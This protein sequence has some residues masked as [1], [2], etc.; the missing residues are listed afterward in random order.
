MPEHYTKSTVEA[1]VWCAKC[2]AFTMHQV[3]SGR[4]GPCQVCIKR[5]NELPKQKPAAQQVGLFSGKVS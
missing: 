4:R 2:H 1:R 3:N 5:L